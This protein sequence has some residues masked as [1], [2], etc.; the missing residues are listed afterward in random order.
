[1]EKNNFTP[2][3][4]PPKKIWKN[5]SVSPAGK[6]LPTPM[7]ANGIEIGKIDLSVSAEF[8]TLMD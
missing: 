8:S 5:P 1:L 2:F 3:G 7:Y 6:I 4:P